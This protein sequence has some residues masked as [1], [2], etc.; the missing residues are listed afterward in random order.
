MRHSNKFQLDQT[1]GTLF[2]S[3]DP[4]LM[5]FVRKSITY[6][7]KDVFL[8][9]HTPHMKEAAVMLRPRQTQAYQGP[10]MEQCYSE[11]HG[12]SI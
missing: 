10:L 3:R 1:L 5:Q 8:D 12:L 2:K 4:E 7:H 9:K 11:H 6:R